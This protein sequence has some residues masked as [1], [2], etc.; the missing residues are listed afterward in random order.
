MEKMKSFLRDGETVNDSLYNAGFSSRSRVYENIASGLGMNPGT[1]RQGGRG[2]Q[3]QYTIVYSPAGRLL[4]GATERGVCAVCMRGS[5]RP[6][7]TVRAEDYP[8]AKAAHNDSGMK[9]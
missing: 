4:V 1:I 9:E 8:L 6:V 2:L 3:M 5:D 7:E